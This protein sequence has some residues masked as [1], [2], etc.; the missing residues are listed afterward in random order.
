MTTLITAL[1]DAA[2]TIIV[3]SIDSS[4]TFTQLRWEYC[5]DGQDLDR[6]RHCVLSRFGDV[7]AAVFRTAQAKAR[8]GP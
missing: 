2:K 6:L 7:A 5:S 8:R 4:V 1:G 3:A